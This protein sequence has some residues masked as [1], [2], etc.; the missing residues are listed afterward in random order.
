MGWKCRAIWAEPVAAH[1]RHLV[2]AR[3]GG[4]GSG[5]GGRKGGRQW[6]HP[7]AV[8]WMLL[9]VRS[10]GRFLH[11]NLFDI[12][13]PFHAFDIASINCLALNSIAVR[14]NRKGS[15]AGLNHSRHRL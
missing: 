11:R 6:T 1:L 12:R 9:S 4:E 2:R 8:W 13:Y 15:P 3:R 7:E 5:N 10:E 14:A